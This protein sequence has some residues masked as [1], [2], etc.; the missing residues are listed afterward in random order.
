[1]KEIKRLQKNGYV[2]IISYYTGYDDTLPSSQ[3][4]NLKILKDNN[5][6]INASRLT[7]TGAETKFERWIGKHISN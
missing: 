2:G 1:M 5:I 4:Y 7:L 3:R 6:F